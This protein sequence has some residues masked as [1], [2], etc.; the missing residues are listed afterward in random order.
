[1]DKEG[2]DAKALQMISLKMKKAQ[3]AMDQV[4]KVDKP[5]V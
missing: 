4:E 2:E 5:E 1:L 3:A